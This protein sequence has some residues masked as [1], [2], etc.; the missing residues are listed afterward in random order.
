MEHPIGKRSAKQAVKHAATKIEHIRKF[1]LVLCV[2]PAFQA[3]IALG[4]RCFLG[5]PARVDGSEVRP[6]LGLN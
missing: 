1:M 4:G 5:W 3:L 2:F 6:L